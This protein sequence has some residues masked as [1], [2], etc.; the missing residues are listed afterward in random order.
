ML[1]LEHLVGRDPPDPGTRIL[2]QVDPDRARQ[3]F[4]IAVTAVAA[5]MIVRVAW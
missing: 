2:V 4:R 5:S 1:A 3:L